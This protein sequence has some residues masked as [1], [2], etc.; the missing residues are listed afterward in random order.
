M[1]LDD[2][3][4]E[5][6]EYHRK[7]DPEVIT[8][9][10]QAFEDEGYKLYNSKFVTEHERRQGGYLTGR[11]WLDRFVKEAKVSNMNTWADIEKAAKRAS[12][13]ES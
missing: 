11:E 6:L 3:L 10:K 2:R 13:V 7:D 12:G 1:T 4:K 5:I 9:I 8:E